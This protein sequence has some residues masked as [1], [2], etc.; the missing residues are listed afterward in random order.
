MASQKHDA[1][2][3]THARTVQTNRRADTEQG[4]YVRTC[5]YIWDWLLL[6]ITESWTHKGWLAQYRKKHVAALSASLPAA[7]KG[8]YYVGRFGRRS[9]GSFYIFGY[10]THVHMPVYSPASSAS[11]PTCI[12]RSLSFRVRLWMCVCVCVRAWLLECN[13]TGNGRLQ[14]SNGCKGDGRS[15]PQ[16]MAPHLRS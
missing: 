11:S 7:R 12:S 6:Y 14:S 5:V 8:F 9:L 15:P 13:V 3:D 4:L 10:F 16:R 2:T 1:H